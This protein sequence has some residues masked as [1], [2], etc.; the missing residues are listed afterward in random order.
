MLRDVIIQAGTYCNIDCSYC[1][2]P[3]RHLKRKMSFDTLREVF[4]EVFSHPELSSPLNVIWHA[5]EPLAL[6]VAFFVKAF[7]EIAQINQNRC[8]IQHRIQTNGILLNDKWCDLIRDHDINLGI[9]VDGPQL[10]HDKNRLSRSGVGTHHLC[11]RAMRM[12]SAHGINY[13]VLCVLTKDSL[14]HPEALIDFFIDEGVS[15]LGFNLEAVE[16]VNATTSLSADDSEQALTTFWLALLKRIAYRRASISIR[17]IEFAV[18]LAS[19]NGESRVQ[20]RETLPLAILTVDVDGNYYT[21]SPELMGL[22]ASNGG[23]FSIGKVGGKGLADCAKSD[24]FLSLKQEIDNGIKMCARDC[25]YFMVCGGGTPSTKFAENGTFCSTETLH[26][27]LNVKTF[28]NML[29]QLLPDIRAQLMTNN[30]QTVP[31]V[32]SR[33]TATIH[34][35]DYNSAAKGEM[36]R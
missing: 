27:R 31:V 17:E 3:S 35:A 16:G 26:C 25:S 23:S 1:Y 8:I 28:Y 19:S 6:G 18:E 15:K 5:G 11:L 7:E 9:S 13:S 33:M 21:F 24:I 2:L 34:I 20:R 14:Q 10:I 32:S 29:S 12:L 22:N 36:D 30:V 4:R